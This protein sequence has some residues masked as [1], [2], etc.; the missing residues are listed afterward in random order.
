MLMRDKTYKHGDSVLQT[1]NQCPATVHVAA[2][3][4]VAMCAPSINPR[5]L[6]YTLGGS[7]P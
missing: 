5:E 6:A 7:I 2:Q 1:S 3:V 4:V